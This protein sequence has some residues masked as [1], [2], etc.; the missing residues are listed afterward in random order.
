MRTHAG[1]L[2]LLAASGFFQAAFALP[3]RYLRQWRWEQMW[4]GQS[5]AAN[6]LLP[7]AWATVAPAAFWNRAGGLPLS[8]WLTV[9]AWGVLWGL[10]GVAWGLTLTRLGIA[11]ANS[12]VFGV[13]TAA[14]ALLPI[15]AGAV[16]KPAHPRLF[17]AG[18]LFCL[19]ATV[20]IGWLRRRGP[21]DAM[22]P[23]PLPFRSYTGVIAVALFAGF[24]SAGY[25]LAYTFA[26]PALRRLIVGGV[27][28]MS[29]TLAIV[30]PAYLGCASVAIPLG[31]LVAA[32]S[33]SLPLFVHAHALR[34]WSLALA[35]GICAAA[36]ALLYGFAGSA[37]GHL[38]PNV[39]FGVFISFLVLS[40]TLLGLAAGEMRGCSRRFIV[41]LLLSAAGL[42]AGALL[43][44]AR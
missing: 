10:G 15:A 16:E 3:V 26:F 6:V 38:S 32:R 5:I 25:G 22:L 35:M 12:F 29:A 21:Q 4:V 18:L 20:L 41:G 39:S 14:G 33:G 27:S 40:G 2:L 42:V 19:L 34:N 23:M 13:T 1:T 8:H 24:A 9:Y 31:V 30:L 44:S 11:F 37:A 28:E 17:A 36:T 43:L 7:L